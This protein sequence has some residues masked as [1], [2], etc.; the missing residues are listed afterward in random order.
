MRRL[1]RYSSRQ[2]LEHCIAGVG[3]SPEATGYLKS[4]PSMARVRFGKCHGLRQRYEQTESEERHNQCG[5]QLT[6]QRELLLYLA[7]KTRLLW[8]Q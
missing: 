8:A 3:I 6:Q 4:N 5:Q 1:R 7:T 2:G